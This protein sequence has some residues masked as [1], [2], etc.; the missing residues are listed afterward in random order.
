MRCHDP[1]PHHPTGRHGNAASTRLD[2]A[3]RGQDAALHADPQKMLACRPGGD[4]PVRRR[5]DALGLLAPASTAGASGKQPASALQRGRASGGQRKAETGSRLP[6]AA[7]DLAGH[8]LGGPGGLGCATGSFKAARSE[9][10]VSPRGRTLPMVTPDCSP[11]SCHPAS[12]RLRMQAAVVGQPRSRPSTDAT[13]G[14]SRAA[15]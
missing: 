6:A 14:S 5:H 8:D 7:K 13:T 4:L 9:Q 11:G 3:A 2:D 1:P 12:S 10:P 15:Q